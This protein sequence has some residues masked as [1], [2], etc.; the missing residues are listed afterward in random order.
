MKD[1]Y[2][3]ITA[4]QDMVFTEATPLSCAEHLLEEAGELRDAIRDNC[5]SEVIDKEIADNFLLLF[6]VCNKRKM[7]FEDILAII[8]KKMD[9]NLVR[10]W[11]KPNDKGY[12]KHIEEVSKRTAEDAK[13]EFTEVINKSRLNFGTKQVR[14]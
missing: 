9:I 10:K 3:P 14:F 13:R 11:G 5:P 7:S 8:D 2:N 12:V 1:R 6:A 4:W